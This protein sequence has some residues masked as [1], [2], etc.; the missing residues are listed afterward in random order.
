MF[1]NS[2][3]CKMAKGYELTWKT[4]CSSFKIDG[5]SNIVLVSFY[6][7]TSATCTSVVNLQSKKWSLVKGQIQPAIGGYMIQ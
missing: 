2:L 3:P 7:Q 6:S 5:I 4:A 1:N